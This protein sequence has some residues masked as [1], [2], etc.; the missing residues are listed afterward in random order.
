MQTGNTIFLALGASDQNHRLYDW[1]RSLAS[2]GC[3]AG[4]AVFFSRLHRMLSPQPLARGTLAL[5][6]FIQAILVCLSAILVQSGLVN[7]NQT[8][9]EVTDWREMAPI[10]LLSFQA[11]GQIVASRVLGVNEVPTVVITSLLCDLMS[12]PMLLTMPVIR[13]HQKRNNRV[14][15]FLLTLLGSIAGGWILKAT[16]QVQ[17]G[18]WIVFSIKVLISLGWVLWKDQNLERV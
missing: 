12:D 17:P 8:E 4:G 11:A 2:I 13:G 6:F 9:S 3:F 7:Q 1:A 14:V 15:G 16:K 5:A 18:L 10:A